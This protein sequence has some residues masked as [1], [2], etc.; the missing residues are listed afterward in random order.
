MLPPASALSVGVQLMTELPELR[1]MVVVP[2]PV[3]MLALP[4]PLTAKVPVPLKLCAA[5]GV[6]PTAST[7]ASARREQLGRR[8]RRLFRTLRII[9][10][11]QGNRR[12]VSVSRKRGPGLRR[13]FSRPASSI[14]TATL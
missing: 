13:S 7:V 6:A 2:A 4:P 12:V 10:Q 1:V 9:D 14:G 5:A 8:L 11:L 3:A